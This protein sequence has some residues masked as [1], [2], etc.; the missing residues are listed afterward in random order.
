MPRVRLYLDSFVP[1]HSV[2]LGNAI[3][4]L[5]NQPVIRRLCFCQRGVA[6]ARHLP[7]I[8]VTQFA[9][10]HVHAALLPV[11]PIAQPFCGSRGFLSCD[12]QV[13]QPSLKF[14]NLLVPAFNH[15]LGT[16][17]KVVLLL[18]AAG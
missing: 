1:H 4:G 18:E 8:P 12:Q 11:S 6:L 14:D 17:A 16:D 10:Q 5:D 15:N 7:R 13:V 3:P 9:L 2:F